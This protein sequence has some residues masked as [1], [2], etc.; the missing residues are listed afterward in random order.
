M[1]HRLSLLKLPSFVAKNLLPYTKTYNLFFRF[2]A[3]LADF[4]AGC[5]KKKPE[6]RMYPQDKIKRYF[7]MKHSFVSL[8]IVLDGKEVADWYR[9]LMSS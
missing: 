3:D 6:E 2:D 1:M 5:L 9:A 4:I 7:I 8:K